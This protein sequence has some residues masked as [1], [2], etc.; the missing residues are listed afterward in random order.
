MYFFKVR[1]I[2]KGNF[3]KDIK[4]HTDKEVNRTLVKGPGRRRDFQYLT[5]VHK[6]NLRE[7]F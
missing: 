1:K 2:Q 5:S 7:Y 4:D 6:T 3:D